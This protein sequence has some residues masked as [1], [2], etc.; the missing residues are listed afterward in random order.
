LAQRV[1][2]MVRQSHGREMS[3]LVAMARPEQIPLSFAQQRLWFLDQ[4][5]GSAAYLLSRAERLLGDLSIEA[6]E[7]S[8]QVLVHRHESLRTTFAMRANYPVQVIH[9]AG[10]Y[11]RPLSKPLLQV[12]DPRNKIKS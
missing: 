5:Q 6:L 7:Q 9:P 10:C 2:Q 1:E 8:L 3:P 4:L 11:I 12:I